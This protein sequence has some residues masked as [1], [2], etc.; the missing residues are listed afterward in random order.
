MWKGAGGMMGAAG[1]MTVAAGVTEGAADRARTCAFDCCRNDQQQRS[2]AFNR[3]RD[4][5]RAVP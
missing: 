2:R 4:K 1:F 5:C 3:C